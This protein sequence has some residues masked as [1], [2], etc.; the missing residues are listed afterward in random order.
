MSIIS[1]KKVKNSTKSAHQQVEIDD[2]IVGEVWREQ[3]RV[4]VSKLKEPLR[5]EMKWRWFA[6]VDGHTMTLGRSRQSF[7]GAG[8]PSK[9][10]AVDAMQELRATTATA[11]TPA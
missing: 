9:D 3:V 7:A 11:S 10:K 1:Y 4:I 5:Q 8:Y 2:Q 6:T